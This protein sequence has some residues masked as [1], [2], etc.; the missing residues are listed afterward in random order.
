MVDG[1]ADS[2]P[3]PETSDAWTVSHR[4]HGCEPVAQPVMN[5]NWMVPILLNSFVNY[6]MHQRIYIF[7]AAYPSDNL[8]HIDIPFKSLSNKFFF[9]LLF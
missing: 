4:P 9:Q 3:S 8:I 5:N 2:E 1:P 7:L 6:T